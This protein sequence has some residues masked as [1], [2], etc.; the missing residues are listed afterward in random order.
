M[1]RSFIRLLALIPAMFIGVRGASAQS[2]VEVLFTP[3][4]LQL[5]LPEDIRIQDGVRGDSTVLVAWGSTEAVSATAARRVLY[6]QALRNGNPLGLPLPVHSA[7]AVPVRFVFVRAHGNGFRVIW[8]DARPGAAGIYVREVGSN[9][10]PAGEETRVAEGEI[11]S[12]DS[13]AELSGLLFLYR[14]G[15]SPLLLDGSGE[16]RELSG[17]PGPESSVRDFA[18]DSAVAFMRGDSLLLFDSFLDSLPSHR[19]SAD[20]GDSVVPGTIT[21]LHTDGGAYEV[22][23]IT[24]GAPSVPSFYETVLQFRL[25]AGTLD[26]GSGMLR[27]VV[28]ADSVF[29]GAGA[30]S[31]GSSIGIDGVDRLRPCNGL[32]HLRI[33]YHTAAKLPGQPEFINHFSWSC[34][35]S[36]GDH[37]SIPS[38][39][40]G[41]EACPSPSSITVER[42]AD[43]G[44]GTV[45]VHSDLF[46]TVRLSVPAAFTEEPVSHRVPGLAVRDGA[47]LVTWSDSKNRRAV[48]LREWQPAAG[49]PGRLQPLESLTLAADVDYPS[50]GYERNDLEY[51]MFDGGG[52]GVRSTRSRM[53]PFYPDGWFIMWTRE[54]LFPFP[55]G[56]RRFLLEEGAGPENGSTGTRS[57]AGLAFDPDSRSVLITSRSSPS[58]VYV[59]EADPS[60]N[61]LWS[62]RLAGG[63][64]RHIHFGAGRFAEIDDSGSVKNFFHD[65][66]V[67]SV[68]LDD[69][70]PSAKFTRLYGGRTLRHQ[71]RSDGAALQ[72]LLYDDRWRPI[73]R[74]EIPFGDSLAGLAAAQSG[75]DSSIALVLATN[76]GVYLTGF[77]RSLDPI[78][79]ADGL[80]LVHRPVGTAT[81]RAANPSAQFRNDTLF[82]VW[83][84]YRNGLPDIYAALLRPD[85]YTSGMAEEEKEEGKEKKESSRLDIFPNPASDRITLHTVIAR[86]GPVVVL[87]VDAAG[88]RVLQTPAEHAQA[89][90]FRRVLDIS[91]LAPGFYRVVLRTEGDPT[92]EDFIIPDRRR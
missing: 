20:Y 56:W 4:P 7:G 76:A 45:D 46:G 73:A 81:A 54:Y 12:V 82:I 72:L 14:N 24:R 10:V 33:R 21:L 47:L 13:P 62:G 9:G 37:R 28:V 11:R 88:R 84:D 23:Y 55:D 75:A 63:T 69:W 19:L 22:A 1:P 80:P 49:E 58:D 40:F 64:G 34:R 2:R 16:L 60:G 38:A 71:L 39:W 6:V 65:L 44:R 79:A 77:D 32:Y 41:T 8:N 78:T 48:V 17:L 15:R 66:P 91:S 50:G 42:I 83:E 27:D 30:G 3:D 59:H 25:M 36:A 18:A 51:G 92:A 90:V 67:D 52:Y 68:R 26:V 61:T 85:R 29:V 57:L 74:T 5:F 53:R 70:N 31:L 86:S 35:V 43:G 89:G 87:V